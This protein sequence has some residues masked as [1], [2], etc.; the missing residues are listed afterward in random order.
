MT[1]KLHRAKSNGGRGDGTVRLG[2]SGIDGFPMPIRFLPGRM[3]LLVVIFVYYFAR[4]YAAESPWVFAHVAVPVALTAVTVTTLSYGIW[5]NG[6]IVYFV[7]AVN[8]D[9]LAAIPKPEAR[10][11]RKTATYRPRVIWRRTDGG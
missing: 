4:L 11:R 9:C 10:R 1:V 2:W 8:L 5:Q 6:L 3:W 7:A